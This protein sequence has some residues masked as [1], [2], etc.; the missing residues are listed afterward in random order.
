ML[1]A[2]HALLELEPEFWTGPGRDMSAG[3]TRCLPGPAVQCPRRICSC[4]AQFRLNAL[5][6][7]VVSCVVRPMSHVGPAVRTSDC[8]TERLDRIRTRLRVESFDKC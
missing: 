2:H 7:R 3:D 8:V 4:S 1:Q 6:R 5:P